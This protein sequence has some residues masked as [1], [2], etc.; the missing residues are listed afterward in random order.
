ICADTDTGTLSHRL[1]CQRGDA[2]STHQLLSSLQQRITLGRLALPDPDRFPVCQRVNLNSDFNKVNHGSSF[3]ASA[4][5]ARPIFT[6][7]PTVRT[8][9]GPA[10]ES[11]AY[12]R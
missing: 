6:N 2:A 7:L 5:T 10:N 9:R 11:P 4:L 12:P 1:Y 3:L 8:T